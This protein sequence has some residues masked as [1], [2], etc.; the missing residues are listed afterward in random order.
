[1]LDLFRPI[2]VIF[3][4]FTFLTGVFYPAVVTAV[5]QIAFPHQANGSII[6]VEDGAVGSALIGQNFSRPEYFWGRLSA[7][8]PV[9]YNAAASSG[10]NFGPRNPSLREVANARLEALKK[11]YVKDKSPVD[12]LTA[13]GS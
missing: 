1:M 7:T 2:V 3:G 8:A 13:S 5:A 6:Y 9:P 4:A 12:L 11:F 10:S